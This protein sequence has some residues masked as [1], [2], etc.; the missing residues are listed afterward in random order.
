MQVLA[1][2]G[3]LCFTQSNTGSALQSKH[4]ASQVSGM[5]MSTQ[6]YMGESIGVSTAA[7]ESEMNKMA[8][9]V[10]NMVQENSEINQ[11]LQ[12]QLSVNQLQN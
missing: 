9:D 8:A 11:E 1:A 7:M 4:T 10:E 5:S 6:S 3:V 2:L 12:N